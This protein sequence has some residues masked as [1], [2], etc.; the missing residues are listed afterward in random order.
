MVFPKYPLK[1]KN[2]H[3]V[4]LLSVAYLSEYSLL[5]TQGRARQVAVLANLFR[6]MGNN[7]ETSCKE[8]PWQLL[9]TVF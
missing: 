3:T 7:R 1:A 5:D 9:Y 4:V 8:T 6:A 2:E